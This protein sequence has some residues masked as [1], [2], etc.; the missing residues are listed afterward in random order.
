MLF[1]WRDEA[2]TLI[3]SSNGVYYKHIDRDMLGIQKKKKKKAPTQAS[4]R[5]RWRESGAVCVF[6]ASRLG[7]TH[8][9][10][11]ISPSFPISFFF[12]FLLN[13]C[14]SRTPSQWACITFSSDPYGFLAAGSE[15]HFHSP[16]QE[17]YLTQ[18]IFSSESTWTWGRGKVL[19]TLK[20][21]KFKIY[22]FTAWA[23]SRAWEEPSECGHV[24]REHLP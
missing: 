12:F 1:S 10:A 5:L 20:L 23:S 8:L 13:T 9:W 11:F 22:L 15:F 3:G 2:F 6:S 16:W 7:P 4:E 18:L 21:V 14:P 19:F 24:S 17:I